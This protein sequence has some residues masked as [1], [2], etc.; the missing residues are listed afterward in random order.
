M[1]R[2][3]V[4]DF[5]FNCWYLEMDNHILDIPWCIHYHAQGFRLESL[6]NFY[7]GSGSRTRELYSISPDWFQ[8]C[9]IYEKFVACREF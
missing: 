9:F 1:L 5:F 3:V 7:V 4:A 8:Y 6:Q 2:T